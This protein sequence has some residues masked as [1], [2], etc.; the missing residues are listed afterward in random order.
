M[1][2]RNTIDDDPSGFQRHHGRNEVGVTLSGDATDATSVV[3]SVR[4]GCTNS[5]GP[6]SRRNIGFWLEPPT[7]VDD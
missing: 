5:S 2:T 4:R 3:Q 1:Q 7:V 6:A